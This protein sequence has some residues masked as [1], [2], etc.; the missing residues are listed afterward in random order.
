MQPKRLGGGNWIT[1]KLVSWL[2]FASGKPR[3]VYRR[4]QDAFLKSVGQ[5]P[6]LLDMTNRLVPLV[7]PCGAKAAE[8]SHRFINVSVRPARQEEHHWYR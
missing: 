6:C 5:F 4:K 8:V 3:Q 7:D 2:N 1:W